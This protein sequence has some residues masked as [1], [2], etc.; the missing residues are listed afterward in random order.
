MFRDIQKN[1]CCDETG[2]ISEIYT[3]RWVLDHTKLSF[4]QNSPSP[5]V[6]ATSKIYPIHFVF[7]FNTLT[8]SGR[9]NYWTNCKHCK[10]GFGLFLGCLS[11]H[12]WN[13]GPLIWKLEGTDVAWIISDLLIFFSPRVSFLFYPKWKP[14][15]N[16]T[17]LCVTYQIM[18][19]MF[20]AW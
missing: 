6:Q 17:V 11:P 4:F 9:V 18:C 16:S 5:Q 3:F 2:W 15:L 14:V 13:H 1:R 12:Q 19:Q 10:A 8:T 20:F 7:P